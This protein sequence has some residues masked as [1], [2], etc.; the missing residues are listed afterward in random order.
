[1]SSSKSPSF[2]ELLLQGVVLCLVALHVDSAL[3]CQEVNVTNKTLLPVSEEAGQLEALVGVLPRQGNWGVLF[4]LEREDHVL[5]NFIISRREGKRDGTAT[6]N[7]YLAVKCRY[8]AALEV[9]FPWP[10]NR[11]LYGVK[12]MFSIAKNLIRVSWKADCN[13]YQ[14]I[15]TDVCNVNSLSDVSFSASSLRRLPTPTLSLRCADEDPS[16]STDAVEGTET[17]P[18]VS[19]VSQLY[20]TG[21]IVLLALALSVV[22]LFM[23]LSIRK[24]LTTQMMTVGEVEDVASVTR[25]RG[26]R[27][28]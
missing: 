25:R 14:D 8:K 22:D 16:R 3:V 20:V 11:S 6:Y 10:T 2:F 18:A 27:H 26:N 12:F 23:I 19:P 21:L 13:G 1:M 9:P 17:T 4:E 24:R 7:D 15:A 28:Y 5:A